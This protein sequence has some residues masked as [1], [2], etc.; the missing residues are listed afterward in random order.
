[1]WGGRCTAVFLKC[2]SE[3]ISVKSSLQAKPENSCTTNGERG[4]SK[5]TR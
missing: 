2:K 3:N 5:F 1:M 4:N